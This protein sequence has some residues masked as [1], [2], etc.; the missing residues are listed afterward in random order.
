MSARRRKVLVVEDDQRM[1]DALALLLRASEIDAVFSS[2]GRDAEARVQRQSFDVVLVDL[3]LPD[4]DGVDLIARLR[5][6]APETPA[7]VI[8]VLSAEEHLLTALRAG[9]SGYLYKEDLGTRLIGAIDEVLE[10]REGGEGTLSPN[11]VRL[12]IEYV[13]QGGLEPAADRRADG[14]TGRERKILRLFVDGAR[15]EDVARSLGVSV[16]TVRTHV[17]HIYDKL[18]VSSKTEAITVASRLGVLPHQRR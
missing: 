11:V 8:T 14:L 3:G 1:A 7:L 15:Y 9:A 2:T 10:Q 5:A 6:L 13:R 17:R 18:S 16:N 12:L 4:V